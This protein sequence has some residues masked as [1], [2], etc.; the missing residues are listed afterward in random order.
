MFPEPLV[1]VVIAVHQSSRPIERAVASILENTIAAVRVT[2]VVHN[3]ELGAI[4][5]RLEYFEH[6]TRLRVVSYVDGIPSPAGPMNYGF[7]LATAPYVSL[8]GSDDEFEAGALDAWLAAAEGVPGYADAVIAPTASQIGGSLQA[9]PPIRWTRAN[10]KRAFKLDPVRDRLAYRSA[11]LGLIGRKKYGALRFAEGLQTGEDQPFTAELWFTP[12]ASIVF[13][14]FAPRYIEHADQPDRVTRTTRS[15]R[16]EFRS[17]ED[18]FAPDQPWLVEPSM[19]L[20][21]IVKFVRVHFFDA[22]IARVG[23]NWDVQAAREMAEIGTHLLKI[24]PRVLR[25]LSSNDERIFRALL[26]VSTDERELQR[27]LQA[28]ENLR[29]FG[30]IFPRRL[31]FAFHSQAPLRFHL[32]GLILLRRS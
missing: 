26:E 14:A 5:K 24:E 31:R 3:T 9:S 23:N 22:A 11:P 13:P 20:S 32:A 18:T 1:D 19:R 10:K 30:A 17:V 27:L 12:G 29:S 7:D 2:V 16:E 15:V 4:A 6:D 28:R 25:L 21:L 8:L